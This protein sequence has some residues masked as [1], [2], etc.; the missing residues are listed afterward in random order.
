MLNRSRKALSGKIMV[1]LTLFFHFVR[2]NIPDEE[3]SPSYSNVQDCTV[4]L[5]ISSI[6]VLPIL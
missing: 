4:I 1:N 6:N 2:T 5:D 3:Y